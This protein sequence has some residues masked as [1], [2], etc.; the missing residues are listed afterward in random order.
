[1]KRSR[2][3]RILI[4]GAA[5]TGKTWLAKRLSEKSGIS[6]FDTD[7]I[8]WKKKYT[9]ERSR[10]EK[11]VMLNNICKKNEWVICSGATSYVACAVERADLII[12]L[13]VN[14]VRGAYRIIARHIKRKS[15]GKE[16]TLKHTLKLI[17]LSYLANHT[18][19]GKGHVHYEKLKAKYP[20]KV[21]VFS[22]KKKHEFLK[23]F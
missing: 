1:M 20:K 9:L 22:H 21:E 16:G 11:E 15:K 2:Y 7:D 5:G 17:Q 4:F 18:S 12:I 3:K 19:S 13:E 8:A 23:E 10:D 14:V 6:Y